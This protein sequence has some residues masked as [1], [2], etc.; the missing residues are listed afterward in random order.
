M[1][2]IIVKCDECGADVCREVKEYKRSLKLKRKN[3][4]NNICSAKNSNRVRMERGEVFSLPP[5]FIGKGKQKTKLSIFKPLFHRIKKHGKLIEITLE[6]IQEIWEKQKGI[7][8]YTKMKL[9]LP[10]WDLQKDIFTASI[11]RIDSNKGYIKDNCQIVSVMANLAK[12]D[13]SDEDMKEF[14]KQIKMCL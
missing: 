12:N 4:C 1:K 10:E 11:D 5:E 6:D 9:R 2:T 13:F 14:C 8:V 7:C 3:F